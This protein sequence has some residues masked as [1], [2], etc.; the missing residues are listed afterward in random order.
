P[1]KAEGPQ[2]RAVVEGGLVYKFGSK[3]QHSTF[4][5]DFIIKNE[6]QADL[7][8]RLEAPPC[9][10]TVA[11][12]QSKVNEASTNEKVIPPKGETTIHSPWEPRGYTGKYRKPA[13]LITNDPENPQLEFAA[14]GEVYPAIVVYPGDKMYFSEASTD[15]DENRQVVAVFS[16]DRPE[17]KINE[18]TSSRP[19]LI[20]ATQEPMTPEQCKGLKIEKGTNVTVH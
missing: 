14:E 3:P 5:K 16:P 8:L 4:E 15:E 1:P 18:M 6:G 19:E 9:S 7:T 12:F 10:C 2:P 13:T 17:L 11:G 20:T